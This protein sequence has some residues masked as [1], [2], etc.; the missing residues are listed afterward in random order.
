MAEAISKIA[1]LKGSQVRVGIDKKADGASMDFAATQFYS[2]RMT[3]DT[4]YLPRTRKM[5]LKWVKIFF[6]WDPYIYSIL[7]MHSRYPLG[8][9]NVVTK[10]NR[11]KTIFDHIL[12]NDSFDISNVLQEASLSYQKFGE[13]CLTGETK[14]PLLNGKTKTIKELHD[15][16]LKDFYVYSVDS[17]GDVVPGM[18]SNVKLTRKDA[19]VIKITL[20]D[21]SSFKCT[22]DHRIMMRDGSYKEAQQLNT[23]DSL[24]PL[25]KSGMYCYYKTM[26]SKV[27]YSTVYNP[28]NGKYKHV[29]RL[30]ATN[31]YGEI[32]KKHVIHH[33]DYNSQ[34]NEPT[35]LQ[36]MDYETHRQTHVR[37]YTAEQIKH[38]SQKTKDLYKKPGYSKMM[39]DK[40]RVGLDNP[41]VRKKISDS[42]RN[43]WANPEHVKKMS[44]ITKDRWTDTE[45]RKKMHESQINSDTVRYFESL[46]PEDRVL[47]S[48]KGSNAALKVNIGRK[49][50]EDSKAKISQSAK[51]FYSTPYGKQ[52]QS[53]RSK[54]RWNKSKE[55]SVYQNH[56]V[57]SIE[58]CNNED[59]YDIVCVDKHHN[60]A[61]ETK[62]GNGLFVHNCIMGMWNPKK[63][64]W[65]GFTCLDPALID[66]REV[67]FTNKVKIFVEIPVKYAKL[68][69]ANKD[70]A[71]IKAI[72]KAL[73]AAVK[74]GDKFIE[75]NTEEGYDENG[76]YY[77]PS[78]CMLINKTDVGE[79]GLRGLPPITPL[80]KDLVYSD[81][82]RKAQ[83][84]RAQRFAYPIEIWKMGD[85]VNGFIPTP[86]DLE[87][88]KNMLTQALSSP[89]YTIVW[90]DMISLEI[91]GHAGSLLNIWDDYNFVENRLLVGLGTNKNVVLGEGGWMGAAK[92]LSMQRLIMDYQYMRDMWTNQFLR[93]F[94]LK[95]ICIAHDYTKKSPIDGTKIPDVPKISWVRNLDV[96]QDEDSKKLYMD[97]WKDGLV[98]SKTLFTK[99]PDLDFIT[100]IR[101]L[102]AEKGTVLDT[103]SRKIP[104]HFNKVN[105]EGVAQEGESTQTIEKT[106]SPVAPIAPELHS[107]EKPNTS[108]TE[109]K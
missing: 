94:V 69:R 21:G 30:V 47:M 101:N 63:S 55:V 43:I 6:D 67:P 70:E 36:I 81:Y 41:E 12:H 11:Q 48:N 73:I 84:S 4:W 20:D 86:E 65:D 7:M 85:H 25:Y 10:D 61:I 108:E 42:S 102:E 90:S 24:M 95:P 19:E 44:K 107:T 38:Y 27:K 14:I 3:P 97:M 91:Q 13:A 45:F 78:V 59:V 50:S 31:A 60:F 53:E 104:E 58:K 83:I 62:D 100:E 87:N 35:N 72:P 34:N 8:E 51:E 74:A 80:L 37:I 75:L 92:T 18:A 17:N 40:I 79:D 2:P 82:L 77:P 23:N 15:E 33:K 32:P 46:S 89:P 29:H 49:H 99:F 9:F 26:K 39:G 5:L 1:G 57:V 16:Q 106:V 76:D 28:R 88:F 93:N 105:D 64:I 22:P 103:D 54:K 56:K 52:C 109:T 71:T 98:S 66:V 96:Q 68:I